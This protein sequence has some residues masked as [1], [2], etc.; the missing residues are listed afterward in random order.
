MAE[1][2]GVCGACGAAM[3]VVAAPAPVEKPAGLLQMMYRAALLDGRV[4]SSAAADARG[5]GRAWVALL[6]AF[7]PARL[8]AA[9]A[10]LSFQDSMLV[11]VNG[12]LF[13][14]GIGSYFLAL[15]LMAALSG[16][17]TGR[18]LTLGEMFRGLAY[19]QSPGLL[20]VIPIPVVAQAAT[21]WRLVAGVAAIRA[22]T[23]T[24][25]G[26]AAGLMLAGGILMFLITT[27]LTARVLNL[28][29]ATLR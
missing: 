12:A 3:E 6:L 20:A 13:V 26:K 1:G 29:L 21:L 5:N 14:S 4:A 27:V 10:M 2:M 28:W 17:V 8:V 15:L 16:P 19:A 23:G 18:K 9:L 25:M 24:S 7:V 22:M 11:L